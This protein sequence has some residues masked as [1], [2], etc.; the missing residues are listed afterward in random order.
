MPVLR[1]SSE[2]SPLL[3]VT[4]T[5]MMASRNDDGQALDQQITG[6][7]RPWTSPGFSGQLI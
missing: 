5:A 7:S 4:D 1:Y 2:K 6:N 3:P